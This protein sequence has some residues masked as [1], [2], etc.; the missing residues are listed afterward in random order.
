[1]NNRVS[2]VSYRARC[3][4]EYLRDVFGAPHADEL[5]DEVDVG[6]INSLESGLVQENDEFVERLG[7]LLDGWLSNTVM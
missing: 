2:M 4:V 5:A 7:G 6:L 3:H 1:M